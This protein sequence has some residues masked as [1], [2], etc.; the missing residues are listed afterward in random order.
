MHTSFKKL[1]CVNLCKQLHH[2][3]LSYPHTPLTLYAIR[4]LYATTRTQTAL[5]DS[6]GDIDSFTYYH[7]KTLKYTVPLLATFR[8]I[9]E[10][11]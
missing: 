2:Q 5:T 4:S 11:R 3:Q 10:V 7:N 6:K 1:L 8:Q 9:Q